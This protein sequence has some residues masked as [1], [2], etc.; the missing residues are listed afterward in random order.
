VHDLCLGGP[1]YGE[2]PR[3]PRF[4]FKSFV[5]LDD[6]EAVAKSGARYL[7]LQRDQRNGEPFRQSE[8]CLDAL[9]ARYGEP[10]EVEPRLAVFDLAKR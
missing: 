1:Y 3:D 4:R 10:I 7:L 6:R 9:K 8:K 2:V 5:Y